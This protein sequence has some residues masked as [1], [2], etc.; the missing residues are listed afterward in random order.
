MKRE[1]TI[2]MAKCHK[3]RQTFGIRA[4]KIQ[5]EWHFTWT[6]AIDEKVAKC[7]GYDST[8]VKGN[9]I[10]DDEY[11]G[12]TYCN[13]TAFCQCGYCH[14]IGCYGG[15]KIHTCPFCRNSGKV[16]YTESYGDI[17]GGGF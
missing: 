6:F 8:M 1:V 13:S 11:P 10:I 5:Q 14:K 12:C 3:T 17:K 7:E 2:I 16:D 4:E 9:I 15:E